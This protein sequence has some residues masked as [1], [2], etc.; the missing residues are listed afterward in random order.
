MTAV[1]FRPSVRGHTL[2]ELMMAV[3][4]VGFMTAG[5]A[6]LYMFLYQSYT[7]TKAQA[8][9]TQVMTHTLNAI[10]KELRQI[11]QQP[12]MT[13]DTTLHPT[14]GSPVSF[15]IPL[16]TDPT[17]RSAD[18]TMQYYIGSWQG[19]TNVLLQRLIRGG[20]TYNP[21]PALLDFE[22][23]RENPS[24]FNTT[25]AG[26]MGMV[27]KDPTFRYDDF[28]LYYD[29]TYNLVTVGV[30]ASIADRSRAGRRVTKTLTTSVAIR[31]TY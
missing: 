26:G 24:T 31:N 9:I 6:T 10:Q 17:N 30:T 13:A 29:S 21:V 7:S 15:K 28:A 27:I 18:D 1:V 23:Y 14:S 20:T 11:A 8:D 12:T 2:I 22:R 4:I 3:A 5:G 25:A 16:S 19:N